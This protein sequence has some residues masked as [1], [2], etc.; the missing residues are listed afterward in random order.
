MKKNTKKTGWFL[1]NEV[2]NTTSEMP[3]TIISSTSNSD[4]V[5]AGTNS[6]AFQTLG[7]YGVPKAL[8]AEKVKIFCKNCDDKI[9]EFYLIV[10][11]SLI[12]SLRESLCVKCRNIQK[13]KK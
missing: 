11:E 7:S 3:N 4:W 6:R 1:F 13:V 12:F 10:D 8:E 5:Y 9:A 2:N